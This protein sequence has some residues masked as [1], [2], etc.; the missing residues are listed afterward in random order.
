MKGEEIYGR[1]RR[2]V[3]GVAAEFCRRTD[4]RPR[5]ETHPP[6]ASMNVCLVNSG[7]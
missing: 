4:D 6:N 7:A 1:E 2:F 3:P 5:A